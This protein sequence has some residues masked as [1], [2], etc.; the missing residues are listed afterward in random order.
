MTR[1]DPTLDQKIDRLIAHLHDL[2]DLEIV[3]IREQ[4]LARP[5]LARLVGSIDATLIA[6]EVEHVRDRR[7]TAAAEEKARTASLLER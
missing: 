6:R 4:A 3:R 7:I 5:D 1:T 2:S